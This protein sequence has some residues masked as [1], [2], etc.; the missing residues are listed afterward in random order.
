LPPARGY[1]ARMRTLALLL[2]LLLAACAPAA[3]E[4]PPTQSPITDTPTTADRPTAGLTP[5]PSATDAPAPTAAVATGEPTAAPAVDSAATQPPTATT[6]PSGP[7]AGRNDDGTFF[8]GAAD[9]PLTL[10]DYSD[11]L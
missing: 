5:P 9:A 6:A 11:F 4:V 1:N 7:V 10:T 3:D 8:Y 2:L